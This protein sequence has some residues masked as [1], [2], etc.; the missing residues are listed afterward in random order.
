MTAP[1]QSI[2]PSPTPSI[3]PK[4]RTE[5]GLIPLFASYAVLQALDIDSTRRAL[6]AGATEQNPLMRP[7]V[8]STPAMIAF[9][10]AATAGTLVIANRLAKQN[11]V[12]G[13]LL[14]FALNSAYIYVVANNY[15]IA[16]QY[17]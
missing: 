16:R 8:S 17:P 10:A 3:L 2:V 9:K 4:P 11:R 1:A 15:K 7:I 13:Y 5:K 12:A 6:N 14:M